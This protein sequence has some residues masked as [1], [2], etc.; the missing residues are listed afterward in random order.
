[1]RRRSGVV[2]SLVGNLRLMDYDRQSLRTDSQPPMNYLDSRKAEGMK[3]KINLVTPDNG[4]RFVVEMSNATLPPSLAAK[5][6]DADLTI[7]IV[8]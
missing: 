5:A 2:C 8:V 1:M 4:E 3:F 7:V 6:S